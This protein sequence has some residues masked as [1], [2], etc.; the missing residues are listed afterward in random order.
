MKNGTKIRTMQD[1]LE[2]IKNNSTNQNEQQKPELKASTKKTPKPTIQSNPIE[3][4]KSDVL[5]TEKDNSKQFKTEKKASSDSSKNISSS[6]PDVQNDKLK[7]LIRKISNQTDKDS[8]S[9]NKTEEKISAPSQI[10]D[11]IATKKAEGVAEIINKL[12]NKNK[13][14]TKEDV[15]LKKE[16]EIKEKNKPKEI[17]NDLVTKEKP[18]DKNTDDINKLKKLVNKISEEKPENNVEDFES[19]KEKTENTTIKNTIPLVQKSESEQNIEEKP[20]NNVED[21]ESVKEKTENT[22]IKKTLPIVQELEPNIKKTQVIKESAE[23]EEAK[24][25]KT[26]TPAI[27]AKKSFWKNISKKL[28]KPSN[29]E[30]INDLSNKKKISNI[31]TN[32]KVKEFASQSGVLQDN[33]K[34]KEQSEKENLSKKAYYKKSYM[35]PNERLIH[36]KQKYYSSVSKR[37]K[38]REKKDEIENLKD[39]AKMKKQKKIATKEEKYKKLKKGIIQKYN[40][41]LFSLPWKKIIPVAIIILTLTGFVSWYIISKIKQ[42]E[43]PEPPIAIIGNEIEK[44]LNIENTI[45][46]AEK[47]LRG[48]NNL[49]ADA[50]TIFN[51]DRSIATIKLFIVHDDEDKADKKMLPLQKA[52]DAIGITDIKEGINNLPDG[53][54]QETTG[55]Y[56]LFLFKTKKGTLRYGLAIEIDNEQ[57]MFELMG[58]WEE[59]GSK[60]KKM[61]TVL[62]PL[63]GNDRNF[64][65]VFSPL[66][67]AFYQDVRIRYVNLTSEETAL[68]YFIYK[69]ILVFATSKDSTFLMIDLMDPK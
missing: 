57:T 27:P 64:G 6:R 2:D 9:E 68:D 14:N 20:E 24:K 54:L 67:T 55:N 66:S 22:T 15:G 32:D 1:D 25:E 51:S 28:K 37:I 26:A 5:Q 40:I 44:F 12:T 41:K 7:E 49:E 21:F 29:S 62:K 60:S 45:T 38:L 10:N 8:T 19:V 53:F 69:N 50:M 42:P 43:P 58:E 30:K 3:P 18:N 59:E 65:E 33:K 39:T 31:K 4:P 56:N 17:L 36:G 61:T 52:L 48:F 35:S 34:D 47:D 11:N 13:P 46:I 23:K 16:I 63:F